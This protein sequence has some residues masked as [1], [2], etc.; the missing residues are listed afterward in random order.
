MKQNNNGQKKPLEFNGDRR[1]FLK[2]SGAVSS[3]AI[4]SFSSGT[5]AAGIRGHSRLNA[6]LLTL[7]PLGF[8]GERKDTVTGLYHLGNGYR[9]YNP[10]LMRFHACDS[11]SPFG[12]SGLNSY[13]YCLGDPVNQRDPSGHFAL[14]SLLI[15]AIVG[16]VVGAGISAAAEGIQCAVNPEHKFDWKQVGIGAALGFISGGFG[17][18]AVGTKTGIQVGL[19]VSDA[20]VSG[21][22]DFG[23]NVA[24]GTPLKQAAINAG[25]GAGI[26]LASFG[27]GKGISK[28][29]LTAN[30]SPIVFK[31]NMRNLDTTGKDLY[32]FTDTYKGADRLNIVAHGISIADGTSNIFR[33]SGQS[34]NAT[35]LYT[36]IS[37][38]MDL[39]NFSNIRTIM[40]GSADGGE[41]SF[42][43]QLS[44]L[45]NIPVKSFKNTVSGNF[46]V[47][48][49]NKLMLDATTSLGQDGFD[50]MLRLFATKYSFNVN[51]VNPYSFIRQPINYLSFTYNPVKF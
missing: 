29:R 22:A 2:Q 12:K 18:A 32:C 50:Y 20:V 9:I 24:T 51:K 33:S 21:A 11:M 47:E 1:K 19:A 41:R 4:A 28:I 8:N 49:L 44:N 30:R 26:G 42:G 34:M 14:L 39:N 7:N 10:Q 13:A 25:I 37:K 35:E 17:A 15:G 23:L 40:C 16:A 45:T 48:E 31:G 46:E 43:K 27:I 5:L 3:L 6:H 38:R 36:T